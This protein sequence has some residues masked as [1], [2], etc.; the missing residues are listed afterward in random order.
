MARAAAINQPRLTLPIL[1]VC[2]VGVL[3]LDLA[4]GL[5]N[6][7]LP[8]FRFLR[9]LLARSTAT[10]L[11]SWTWPERSAPFSLTSQ[12]PLFVGLTL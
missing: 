1:R 11:S 12:S 2:A 10:I 9:E 5:P 7:D 6:D 8:E 3:S 4:V